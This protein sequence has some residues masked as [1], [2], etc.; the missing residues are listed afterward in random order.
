MNNF[1]K[2]YN[3]TT[4]SIASVVLFLIF[5]FHTSPEVQK[6]ALHVWAAVPDFAKEFLS[7]AA[8]MLALYWHGRKPD[9]PEKV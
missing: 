8:A 9:T 4:H 7:A 6:F 5:A 1:L 2:K 3:L